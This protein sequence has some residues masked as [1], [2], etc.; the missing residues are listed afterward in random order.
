[1]SKKSREIS[2]S[3]VDK[4]LDADISDGQKDF[5]LFYLESSNATHAYLKAFG[6]EKKYAAVRGAELLQDEKVAKVISRLKK[7]LM[8]S[9]NV[10]PAQYIEYLMKVANADLGDYLQFAE[11]EIPVYDAEGLEMINPDTGEPITKKVNKMH[12]VNSSMVDTSSIISVKQ[13]R[14]GISIQLADKSKAWDK[15]ADYFGWGVKKEETKEVADSGILK[16]IEGKVE[17]T[18]G[19]PDIYDDLDKTLEKS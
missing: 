8:K 15:L 9:Y 5:V 19:K 18:W 3:I 16:A 11:E 14:D 10:D 13:G 12:L 1:M 4:I 17:I 6:G 2:N 7:I